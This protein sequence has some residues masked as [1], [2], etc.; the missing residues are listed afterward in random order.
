MQSN[1][2]QNDSIVIGGGVAGLAVA[3]FLAKQGKSVRLLE[4]SHALGG[5]ARTKQQDGFYLNIGPHALYRGGRGI[6]VL[7][8]LGVEVQGRVPS[9]SGAFSVKNGTKHTFPAGIVSLLTTSLFNL[10]AKL[11]TARLLASLAKIDGNAVMN[12][13]AREWL[14]REISHADVKDFLMSVFRVS[15]YANAPELLS[16]GAALEQV[17]LALA[18]SVLYL[19][20]GWQT[21]VDGLADAAKRA[22]VRIETGAKIESV[23]RD[24]TGAVRGVRFAD[25]R[26]LIAS[27]VVIASSPATAVNLVER[28]RQTQI[29]R[30]A[31]EAIPVKAAALDIALRYLPKSKATFALGVDRPLYLSVHSA[32]ARLA[33]E[34]GAMIHV[35]KY[36]APESEDSNETIERELEGLLDLVQPGWRAALAHRRFLPD[37]VVANALPLAERGGARPGPQ[38]SDVPGLFVVGDWVGKEGMLVDTSLASAKQAAELIAGTQ[39]VRLAAAS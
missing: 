25:G 29:A 1:E 9:V 16:A 14:D 17:K 18:K 36:L 3:T 30:W 11:E 10:S 27:T 31:D 37:L 21:I 19:D 33:P 24:L 5:R 2:Q 38:V 8:E 13:S 22:G 12:M 28:G 6:E 15:T 34:G 39:P 32:T 4:Q 35:A 26:T 23:E 20:G 7:R